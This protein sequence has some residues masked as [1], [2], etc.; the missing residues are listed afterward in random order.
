MLSARRLDKLTAYAD[1][2]ASLA[3]AALDHIADPKLPST[4][5][6]VAALTLVAEARVAGDDR[7]PPR[8][9]QLGDQILSDAIEEEV[10]L[11][12]AAEVLKRQHRD[13]RPFRRRG[14]PLAI[15]CD[16]R[17]GWLVHYDAEGADRSRDV[18]DLVFAQIFE[19]DRQPVADLVAHGPADIDP[20]GFRQALHPGADVDRL[21]V[22][23][24]T[25]GDHIAHCDGDAKPYPP[26]GGHLFSVSRHLAL[27][28]HC[29]AHRIDDAVELDQEPISHGAHD[30]PPV[31]GDGRVEEIAANP[32]QVRQG[33]FFVHP[34]QA[35]IADDIGAH[36]DRKPVLYPQNCSP[37]RGLLLP[38]P[39]LRAS[40]VLALYQTLGGGS[41]MS[42]P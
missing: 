33:A 39:I 15:G 21:P 25:I 3:E 31:F 35:G 4:S 38:K 16:R 37:H 9:R 24:V 7:E 10:G 2:V 12:V 28:L 19:G 41:E 32:V 6:E 23:E 29:A 22:N 8:P 5:F 14:S 11:G 27:H 34:H 18:L 40:R 42:C 36:D 20:T 1:A 13:R 17:S 26:V 30:A